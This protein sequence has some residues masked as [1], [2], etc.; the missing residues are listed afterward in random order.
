MHKG[1]TIILAAGALASAGAAQAQGWGGWRDGQS[2]YGYNGGG[3]WAMR[4]VCSGERAR[5]MEGRLRHETG[6]GDIDPRTADRIHD[7]IDR[8][9]DRS[10]NE[11]AEG[12]R[13][14]I[15][16]ISQRFDRIQSW[17][18]NAAHDRGWGRRW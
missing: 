18:E 4:S 7:A 10:R 2:G 15:W 16:E 17:I 13:R 11:C 14:S 9:E 5:H 6:D 12:D 3:E 1:L 8:L